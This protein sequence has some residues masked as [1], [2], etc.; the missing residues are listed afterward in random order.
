MGEKKS[1]GGVTRSHDSHPS[2][3][4]A[5]QFRARSHLH[6]GLRARRVVSPK[7]QMVPI[8]PQGIPEHR[9]RSKP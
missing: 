2:L 8:P 7:P 6:L 4:H 3:G 5:D 9:I 1:A